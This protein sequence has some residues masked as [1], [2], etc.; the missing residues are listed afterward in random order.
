MSSKSSDPDI[1]DENDIEQYS[2]ND[3]AF[4]ADVTFKKF[5]ELR[6]ANIEDFDSELLY[7]AYIAG[8]PDVVFID[9]WDILKFLKIKNQNGFDAIDIRSIG[10]IVCDYLGDE[11]QFHEVIW[12]TFDEDIASVI[13]ACLGI[14]RDEPGWIFS[15]PF[16]TAMDVIVEIANVIKRYIVNAEYPLIGN[17]SVYKVADSKNGI[18]ALKLRTF[19]EARNL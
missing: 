8:L 19:G 3:I 1:K 10:E 7:R 16:N 18:L 12:E 2:Q 9:L 11:A 13:M 14:D 15:L 4:R 5:F 6:R 17:A